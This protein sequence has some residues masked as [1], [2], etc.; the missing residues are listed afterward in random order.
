VRNHIADHHERFAKIIQQKKLIEAIGP[1]QGVAL[2]RVPKG[3]DPA[4]PAADWIR[5]KQWLFFKTFENGSELMKSPKLVNE[6][7][8]RFKLMAPL[9]DFLNEPLVKAAR[10]ATAAEMLY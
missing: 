8:G 1:L 10:K 7:A 2:T 5:R 9:I 6:V 3:F 4:H